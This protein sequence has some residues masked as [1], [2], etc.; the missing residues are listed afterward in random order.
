MSNHT[1]ELNSHRGLPVQILRRACPELAE[2]GRRLRPARLPGAPPPLRTALRCHP[3]AQAAILHPLQG[4]SQNPPQPAPDAIR[5]TRSGVRPSPAEL[6]E[7]SPAR[8]RYPSSHV[9]MQSNT[10]RAVLHPLQGERQTRPSSAEFGEG[11]SAH[12]APA[13]PHR[14]CGA[15]PTRRLSSSFSLEETLAKRPSCSRSGPLFTLSKGRGRFGRLRPKSVR[16][17][18]RTQPQPIPTVRV[19]LHPP[20][21]SRP[22]S[23]LRKPLQNA[24]SC[25]SAGPLFTL[26]KGRGR[27]GR[28]RPKSVRGL[29]RTPPPQGPCKSSPQLGGRRL[30]PSPGGE[31]WGEGSPAH[32]ATRTAGA[33]MHLLQSAPSFPSPLR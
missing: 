19:A 33:L 24:P 22:P 12:P 29:P 17:P 13:H 32:P 9:R 31:G 21:A 2:W 16:G 6:S 28:L 1:P 11:S 27:L 14:P 15:S 4:Q 23:P 5:G 7:G 10:D 20:G 26:S 8:G 18:P 3:S 30:N 25:S